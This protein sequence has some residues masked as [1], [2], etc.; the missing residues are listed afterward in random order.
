ML[1]FS[2]PDVI[3]T[4]ES[5]LDG[6][7]SGLLLKRLA[8]KLHNADVRLEAWNYQAWQKRPMAEAVAWVSDF[9]FE[10]RFD[11]AGWLVVDHH[12]TAHEAKHARFIHDPTKSAGSLV[13]EL[14]REAG[15]ASPALE[16]LVHLN[17]VA[18]IFLE[19]DPEFVLAQDYASLVKTYNFWN[20]YELIDG[21]LEKLLEHP[22]LE[23]IAAKRRVEDPI[24]LAW[25]KRHVTAITA[26]LGLV[27]ITVGNSNLIIYQ[28]LDS[29]ATPHA[30]L[31][32]LFRKANGTMVASFRS[33]NGEALKLAEKFQGGG[34]P[35]ASGATLPRSVGN[36]ADAILYL[37]KV[38]GSAVEKPG[39]P[40]NNLESLFSGFAPEK[41]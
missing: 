34:H 1:D 16:R 21:E 4:H 32:T 22:L 37:R 27:E 41:K 38:L 9:T 31:V 3:L 23:V 30:V 35:N 26:G 11:R 25:S 13:Y 2:K 24:G 10:A 33:R 18:D 15:L 40:L 6:F 29:A 5:D 20:L 36:T 28:M 12:S 19:A 39:A 7:V 8:R 14:C 17:N